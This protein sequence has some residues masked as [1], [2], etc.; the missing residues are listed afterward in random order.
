M[1]LTNL[2]T[3]CSGHELIKLLENRK[4]F[5]ALFVLPRS[6]KLYQDEL[7]KMNVEQWKKFHVGDFNT[8]KHLTIFLYSFVPAVQSVTQLGFPNFK[9]HGRFLEQ[10]IQR[11]KEIFK[12]IIM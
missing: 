4:S 1:F 12:K 2:A 8:Y 10:T 3:N 5:V 6:S 9:L 11:D 7:N